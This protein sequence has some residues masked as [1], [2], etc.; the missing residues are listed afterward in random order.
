[1]HDLREIRHDLARSSVAVAEGTLTRLLAALQLL[2]DQPALGARADDIASG[3][4]MFPVR[5]HVIF[6][7]QLSTGLEVVRVVDCLRE[8]SPIDR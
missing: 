7:R 5:D 4:R 8:P 6:Y 2:A 3:Y 1:M